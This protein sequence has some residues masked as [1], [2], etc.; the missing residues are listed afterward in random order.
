M[1]VSRGSRG[2]FQAPRG[3]AVDA[4][5]FVYVADTGNDRIQK[6]S[7]DGAFI[8][9]WGSLGAGDGQFN[10]PVDLAVD[11]D[12]VIYVAEE[13]NHRIQKIKFK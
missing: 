11:P 6:F 13:G 10:Q 9:K 3:I 8:A 1:G 7:G 2:Q 5:G 12:G 4:H